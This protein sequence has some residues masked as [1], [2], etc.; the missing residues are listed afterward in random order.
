MVEGFVRPELY[1]LRSNP[2]VQVDRTALNMSTLAVQKH[3]LFCEPFYFDKKMTELKL[4]CLKKN[5]GPTNTLYF[6]GGKRVLFFNR[7]G[8]CSSYYSKIKCKK[9][10]VFQTQKIGRL[11]RNSR[12]DAISYSGGIFFCEIPNSVGTEFSRNSSI[13]YTSSVTSDFRGN[14]FWRTNG[15]SYLYM[16]PALL[17][18]GRYGRE[19]DELDRVEL[20]CVQRRV[21]RPGAVQLSLHVLYTVLLHLIPI[22]QSINQ[23]I[24]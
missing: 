17:P 3:F 8:L 24:H 15:H 9:L 13:C 23:S 1:S 18:V 4:W 16:Y 22:N 6:F 14:Y 12:F 2:L 7:N 11:W 21:R 19:D 10:T 5:S 20:N